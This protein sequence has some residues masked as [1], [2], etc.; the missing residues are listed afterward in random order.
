VTAVAFRSGGRRGNQCNINFA[1]VDGAQPAV[2]QYVGATGI[3]PYEFLPAATISYDSLTNAGI[4]TN[5]N[6]LGLKLIRIHVGNEST[7]MTGTFPDASHNTFATATWTQFDS[8]FASLPSICNLASTRLILTGGVAPSW[9]TSTNAVTTLNGATQYG[10]MMV[11]IAQRA[12]L[13]GTEIFYWEPYNEPNPKMTSAQYGVLHNQVAS[14]L[15]TYAASRSVT[16]FVGGPCLDQIP[17]STWIADMITAAGKAN[18]DFLSWHDYVYGSGRSP[19]N[20]SNGVTWAQYVTDAT[21]TRSGTAATAVTQARGADATIPTTIPCCMTEW[22]MNYNSGTGTTS[23]DGE[24]W[25]SDYHG[26]VWGALYIWTMLTQQSGANMSMMALYE[27]VGDSR[28]GVVQ[29]TTVAASSFHPQGYL[30]KAFTALMAGSQVTYAKV[31]TLTNLFVLSTVNGSIYGTMF[32]NSDL[33]TSYT[34]TANL[35]GITIGSTLTYTEISA[36]NPTT[37]T[38]TISRTALAN[39]VIPAMSVVFLSP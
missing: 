26:A 1:S 38:S 4:R 16:Y 33:A 21:T 15:K 29:S 23:A 2:T 36:A 6:S 5:L 35:Q 12:V 24:V 25:Q 30:L 32:I 7:I 34:I 13:R 10:V 39:L 31:G 3:S 17:F 14:Q 20:S 11:A 37:L 19:F 9:M 8:L 27:A 28:F 22:N 18:V